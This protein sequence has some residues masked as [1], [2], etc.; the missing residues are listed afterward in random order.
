[1]EAIGRL[2][3]GVAHD[4]NNLLT[5]ILGNAS[6][7]R[8]SAEARGAQAD[9]N[10]ATAIESA[11]QRGGRLASQLLAFARKQV[12]HPEVV[13]AYKVLSDLHD[14][15]S[16]AAGDQVQT[17][18]SADD[19]LWT[20]RVDPGQLESAVLNLVINARD[21]MPAGGTIAITCRNETLTPD[22][23]SRVDGRP[24]EFVRIDVKDTGT[25]IPPE[26]RERVFEPF[27]TTKPIGQGSGLGLAQVHG[28][29][30][31]SDGWV[32][33]VSRMGQGTTVS[34]LLPRADPAAARTPPGN[35]AGHTILLVEPKPT[36]RTTVAESLRSKGHRVLEAWDRTGAS[37][38]IAAPDAITLLI[39][40]A[41]LPAAARGLDLA[42][43]VRRTRPDLPVLLLSATRADEVA[44][45][46]RPVDRCEFLAEP[47]QT[48]DI[49]SV[50]EA[51]LRQGTFSPEGEALHS[52]LRRPA[53]SR[54]V[55][56]VPHPAPVRAA[57]PAI[58]TTLPATGKAAVRLG[59]LPLKALDTAQSD[60]F[61]VGLAEELTSALGRFRW[62]SCISPASV[63]ALSN[64]SAS[65]SQRW[66]DL[67][68]DYLLEGSFRQ[69]G[70]DIRI[71]IRLVNMRE[72]SEVSWSRRFDSRL[73]D[74][75]TLQD[76][77]A[78]DAAAQV[79]PE[80][81]IR[82]GEK[83][84]SRP[85]VN[86]T[87]YGLTLRAIPAIYRL[88]QTGFRAAG[89]LLRQA[90]ELDPTN[91][92]A[93][94]WL[95][96][97]YLL[98][99]GQGWER[100]RKTAM[101]QADSLAHRAIALDGNDARGLTVAGH[102]KAFLH[103]EPEAALRLHTAALEL[104][105]NLALAWCYSG[106]AHSYLGQHAEAIEHIRRAQ[107]LS[108]HD[109]HGFFF[110]MALVMPLLLTGDY[111]MAAQ[112]GRRAREANPGLS[113]TYKGLI[114]ALG[115]LGRR[116]EAEALRRELM[117][118]EP[119]FSIREAIGRSP[120]VRPE[121]L[122]RYAD[123]LRLAGCEEHGRHRPRPARWLPILQRGA[124]SRRPS[125]AELD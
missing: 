107:A 93:H 16:R 55:E 109:P 19:A 68:L 104:N 111:R 98:L 24:G 10:R 12:L 123:G 38:W 119:Y 42:W 75:L 56:I 77:I 20:C 100:D 91:A 27:F 11:A 70:T 59:V 84:I 65:G 33:L 48:A 116:E 7:L 29:A 66:H 94:S 17:R 21:A 40:N 115:F 26:V 73:A 101:Q 61:S 117:T 110:D 87:S 86:P 122:Q 71:I 124:P 58:R 121:D 2:T 99:I 30:G 18:L 114:S 8:A 118:L 89:A 106:L 120:L 4:F 47:Y 34:L 35:A 113:S 64:E 85:Q 74:A 72:P 83:A 96:H 90:L 49:V 28:F 44:L 45:R 88:D 37:R 60:A 22:Q 50:T 80:V 57:P 53:A 23:A 5:V 54:P 51:L 108:P 95:A 105:P 39:T 1:M 15:L 112:F 46:Q 9:A 103:K 32:E 81:L 31:Q 82:E 67:D 92:P 76:Q 78:A 13:S 79:A 63:A 43:E 3:A 36:L 6:A 41:S 69:N 102:I 125:L 14:L 52:E 62:I 25:G 97:W